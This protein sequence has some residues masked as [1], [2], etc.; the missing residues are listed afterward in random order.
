MGAAWRQ[1]GGAGLRKRMGRRGEGE[2]EK[3]RGGKGRAPKLPLNQ[4][5]EP[6]YA[7][8]PYMRAVD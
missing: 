5:P 2:E 3:W 4:G 8:C 1:G 7:T 6:C